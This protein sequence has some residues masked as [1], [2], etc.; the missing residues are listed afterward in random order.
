MPIPR[1][2][3][4]PVTPHGAEPNIEWLVFAIDGSIVST[5][6]AIDI[7]MASDR[8]DAIRLAQARHGSG[9]TA[10]SR[11]E[12]AVIAEERAPRQSGRDRV[13]TRLPVRVTGDEQQAWR[14]AEAE[15]A[16]WVG[17]LGARRAMKRFVVRSHA[18]KDGPFDDDEHHDA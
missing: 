17:R 2:M 6:H 5:D 7:V 9:V 3:P 8:D 14:D 15:W 11:V 13:R 16:D 18:T 12:V 4:R 1:P 10:V